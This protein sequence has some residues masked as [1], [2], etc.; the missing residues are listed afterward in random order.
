MVNAGIVA[1]GGALEVDGAGTLLTTETCLLNKNRNP[2]KDRKD[3]E[4]ELMR[5]TG[6]TKVVWLHGSE[7]DNI[8]DGHVDGIARFVYPGLAVAEVSDDPEDPEYDDLLTCAEQLEKATD[9]R[10]EAINVE[11][12]LRPRWDVMPD[13]GNDFAASYVNCFVS[14]GGIVMPKFG[15]QERDDAARDLFAKLHP[16]FEIVQVDVSEICEGGGGIHCNTQQVPAI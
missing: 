9:A 10:G 16:G 15:D 13:R 14:N 2:G 7:A 1:E 11:R 6:A 5:L 4:A 12:L 8:T 3:I